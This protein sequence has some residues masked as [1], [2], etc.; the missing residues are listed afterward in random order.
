MDKDKKISRRNLLKKGWIALG[1]IA[2]IET[3]YLALNFLSSRKNKDIGKEDKSR[4]V[5]IGKVENYNPNTVTAFRKHFFYLACFDNGDLAAYSIQCTHLGCA[6]LYN[7]EKQEFQCPCHASHFDMQG[8][9]LK[10]PAT[11]PLDCHPIVEKD[12]EL[13]IDVKTVITRSNN[14]EQPAIYR[15]S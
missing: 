8:R 3:L 10:S 7:K 15:R 11:R 1:I 5:S 9:V 12:G 14:G 6:L 2:G 4:L 13:F